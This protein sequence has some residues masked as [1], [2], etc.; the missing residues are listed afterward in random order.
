MSG[1]YER[2]VWI[3]RPIGPERGC[4]NTA[5]V[6]RHRADRM[7]TS[8]LMMANRPER[9]GTRSH[10]LKLTAIRALMT[11]VAKCN[12]DLPKLQSEA[13]TARPRPAIWE[14]YS[15]ELLVPKFEQSAFLL[16]NARGVRKR[17]RLHIAKPRKI[18]GMT[19]SAHCNGGVAS[20]SVISHL[21]F[22]ESGDVRQMD[23]EALRVYFIDGIVIS[24]PPDPLVTKRREKAT[25]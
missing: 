19:F 21:D 4:F 12:P 22:M 15:R 3:G 7:K 14:I 2:D 17:A 11:E 24:A 16:T 20:D 9:H 8:L 18:S 1:N 6:F 23:K 13:T 5:P 25:N 10:S